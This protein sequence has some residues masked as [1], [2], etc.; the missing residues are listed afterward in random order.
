MV[1]PA[2]LTLEPAGAG[3]RAALYVPVP[4]VAKKSK[5]FVGLEHTPLCALGVMSSGGGGGAAVPTT[6]STV[7]G[8]RSVRPAASVIANVRPVKQVPLGITV[9][10]PPLAST[11]I[12][13]SV[14]AVG[15]F[16]TTVYGGV[17]PNI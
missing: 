12:P 13:T 17:P 11:G 14:T 16:V 4:P 9:N 15:K 3:I 1:P 2:T 5:V 7:G 10:P 6:L 8:V